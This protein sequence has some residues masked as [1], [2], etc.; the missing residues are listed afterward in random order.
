MSTL[1]KNKAVPSIWS[2]M[3]DFTNTES[4]FDKKWLKKIP[5]VNICDRGKNYDIEVVAPGFEKDDFKVAIENGVLSISAETHTEKQQDD[6]VYTRKEFTQTSFTRSFSLPE[7][8]S[9]D[10]I[11]AR[12]ANGIL[13]LHLG[14]TASEKSVKKEITV[15]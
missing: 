4:L 11:T 3:E 15:L 1:V 6:E 13:K 10:G 14:K 7:N 2:L 9:E 12:Y 8:V 5:A